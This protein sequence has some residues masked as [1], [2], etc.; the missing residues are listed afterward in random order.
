MSQA[1]RHT[2]N[3]E[4]SKSCTPAPGRF[5]I[6][7][8][9]LVC[10]YAEIASPLLM[11]LAS[12]PLKVTSL[13]ERLQA[14]M[15]PRV[16]NK[17][18]WPTVAAITLFLVIRNWSRLTL[19]PHIKWL[20]AHLALAG[21]SVSWAFKPEASFTRFV[22]Q[23][24]IV[25]SIVLPAMLA[26][27]TADMMRGLYLCF[28]F[29][30]ILN[31]PFVFDQN[32]DILENVSIGYPGY[33]S[34][35]GLL[36]ECAAIAFLLSLHEVLYPGWRRALGFI[37]IGI[38]TYLMIISMSKGSLGL[39]LVA[40]FLAWLALFIGRRM[41]V[42]P[43]I[44]LLS[45][46]VCYWILSNIVG[47]LI[48]RISWHLYANYTL[49][50]RT[51]IWN[52]VNFEIARKPLFGWGYQSFW[53]VGLDA[54]SIVD[55]PGWI[56]TLPSSHNGYLDTNLDLGYVGLVVLVIFIFT[57]LRAIG[58]LAERQP[59]RAWVLLTLAL[60]AILTNF[61]ESAWMHGMDMVWLIFLIVVAETGRWQS[62]S[63]GV[64]ELPL[65]VP[66]LPGRRAGLARACRPDKRSPISE[67]S[68]VSWTRI[69]LPS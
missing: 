6:M 55:A 28:A 63:P 53:L 38:A 12:A 4:R 46:P 42:C 41:R 1:L 27:R 69:K 57:S 62:Y 25:T 10:A 59:A 39:S 24:I 40:P 52:F 32:P 65:A 14:N 2:I 23:A 51:D 34:F 5:A 30:L 43:T 16:E 54:P 20:L 9:I 67:Q 17:I 48:S 18:F 8:P 26:P 36:G 7:I 33:F 68:Y 47:D 61:L 19:P 21:L 31:I 64:P 66:T 13:A 35:K 60:F 49:S 50:G 29:A 15:A 22:L 11:D 3:S 45:I 44:V 58:R 37:I 56:K